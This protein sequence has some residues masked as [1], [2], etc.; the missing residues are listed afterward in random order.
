MR[1]IDL[2][3]TDRIALG[4]QVSDKEQA[5]DK[6][7]EL[8]MA[9]GCI[10]DREAYRKAILAREEMS[11][12]A[13]EQGIAVPHAKSDAVSAPSLAAMTLTQGVDYGAMD[14]QPSDLFF[15]IAAPLNGDLHL[16]ILSRLMVLLMDGE[17][18][19]A[20]RSAADAQQFMAVIDRFEKEKY[21]Q[22][23]GGTEQKPVEEKAGYRVLAVTACP[24]GIAHTYMA[25]EALEKAAAQMNLSIKVET[26][27][28]A[29]VKNRLTAQ[30]IEQA[31]GIIVA[32]DK[33][34]E[35]ARF[36]GKKV[37]FVP[38]SDGIHKPQQLLEQ[39]E[40]GTV[41]VYEKEKK[42]AV[43]QQ[44]QGKESFG[45]QLYKHL[46]NGV[47]HMLPFVIGGGILIAIAFLL[48][49]YSIN[50]ANFGMNT[51]LAAFFKTVGGVAFDFM[52]PILAGYIAYSIA[53]RP[54]LAVGIVGGYIAKV[55]NSFANISGENAV[56][57]GFLAALLAGFVA[58]YLVLGIKKLADKLP[59]SMEGIKP[60]LIYPLFG[61]LLI[62]VFM[63]AV[64]PTMA[65]INTGITGFLNSMGGSSKILLGCIVAGMM[66]IDMGGPFN[67]AAYVFGTA[68]IASG[69]Y[70][71]MAA[72]MIGGMI[73]PLAVALATT[74]FKK[75]FT[76]EERKSGVV[77]YIMGLCFI[78]EGVIPFAAADPLR[79][80]PSCVAGSAV[81]G[82]LSMLFGCTLR[83]PH[84]GIF[85]FPVVGNV[86]GYLIA[87]AAGSLVG[88]LLLGVLKKD[89]VEE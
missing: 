35:T 54:G 7:V 31:D 50:P 46:M 45:R 36:A 25:A 49:D 53:D 13:I 87:L 55:G 85:V 58:G 4:A 79:V 59:E 6:L 9:G 70:D 38:V 2:L 61:V 39:I 16:E 84:G 82:G 69:N 10:A 67:K 72:V 1:I 28:S 18:V 12:T 86:V 75:K 17:F 27:G 22:E 81:A 83:A 33:N 73:P 32:A 19:K 62:G 48:D 42:A 20:L 51:P 5:I 23:V 34:V 21:P 29:G 74:F 56:S 66:S 52:L 71:V 40:S 88:M 68:S 3:S 47:S 30:E 77:N 15:M 24:T 41:A 65:A 8:Q 60:V 11:S 37:L 43:Q 26:N 89:K 78:T 64:N 80:I 76:S 44:E 63:F 14:G 57:G